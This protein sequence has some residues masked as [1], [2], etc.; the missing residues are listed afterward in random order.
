MRAPSIPHRIGIEG[1]NFFV[2]AIAWALLPSRMLKKAINRL[3]TRHPYSLLRVDALQCTTSGRLRVCCWRAA[4]NRDCVFACVYRAATVRKSV[5]KSL[6]HQPASQADPFPSR[7]G[8]PA[9]LLIDQSDESRGRMSRPAL[10]AIVA[11]RPRGTIRRSAPG[12]PR[13]PRAKLFLATSCL[14]FDP[15]Y[16][17]ASERNTHHTPEESQLRPPAARSP[18]IGD[19]T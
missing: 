1:L 10:R 6:F 3:L 19:G 5:P 2:E 14:P 9:G 8:S 17:Q 12:V 7:S 15:P 16:F 4:Q 18:A 13:S 11:I